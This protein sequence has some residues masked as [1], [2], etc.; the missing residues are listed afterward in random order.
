MRC[1]SLRHLRGWRLLETTRTSKNGVCGVATWQL[2]LFRRIRATNDLMRQGAGRRGQL[3]DALYEIGLSTHLRGYQ[4]FTWPDFLDE[5]I[6][7]AR[8]KGVET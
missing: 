4:Y 8:V 3:L 5:R 2:G 7:F 6:V 1:F